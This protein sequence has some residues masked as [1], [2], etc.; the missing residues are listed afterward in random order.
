MWGKR[1]RLSR[2]GSLVYPCGCSSVVRFISI[3]TDDDNRV[4]NVL[5]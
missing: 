3:D 5:V 2:Y 4:V 1:L